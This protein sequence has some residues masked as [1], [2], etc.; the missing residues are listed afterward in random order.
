[1]SILA[2]TALAAAGAASV[3]VEVWSVRSGWSWDAAA[4][5]LLAGLSLLAGAGWATYLTIGCR[6]LLALAG[7][8]WFLATPQVVSGWV[9]HDA[10]LLG[11]VWLAPLA[12]AM[13]ALPA[14]VP[15]GKTGRAAGILAW[16][17]ALPM[18]AGLGWLT[19]ATGGG[20]AFAAAVGS[21]RD[22]VRLPRAAAAAVGAMTGA[23]G[24]LQQVTGQGSALEPFVAVAVAVCGLAVL[25]VR[26]AG[27]ATGS[28]VAG[29]VVELGRATDARSLQSRLARAV[30]DPRLRL[31]YQLAPGL[32]FVT[33]SGLAADATPAGRIVT[34]MG[35]SGPLVAAIEHDNATL[36]DPRLRRAVLVVG[37]LAVRRLTGAA[38]AAQHSLELA[39]SR[40]R[41]VEADTL[42]RRQ[43][44]SEV[45][46]GPA[47]FVAR[48]LEILDEALAAAP[49]NLR[50]DVTA[51]R[52]AA[53]TAREELAGIASGDAD[54]MLAHG[55]L[56]AALTE[57]THSAG[58]EASIRIE[59]ALDPGLSRAA[60]FA[61]AEALTNALKH[62]GPARIWL[63]ASID[64]DVLRVQVEDDGVGG[65]DPAG[66]GLRSLAWRLAEHRG[67]LH[68]RA[69]E[70]GGTVVTADIPLASSDQ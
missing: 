24:I 27:A 47:R 67:T 43:F 60:W 25:T 59:G 38:E 18:L 63:N 58:G 70:H 61:A 36:T 39:D 56:P 64:A 26:P 11:G 44:A 48:C 62:A 41:L 9:G 1:M 28:G 57:L 53:E 40:R 31:L 37:R 4:L 3:A 8:A 46:D 35:Q 16:V 6:R 34:V 20:L 42:A 65:A 55:D 17:R 21:G 12:T 68:V 15:P 52:A 10:A 13:L 22:V 50:A 23:A 45:A 51:A 29:L 49:P 14:A 69:G 5:D 33:A 66:R 54:R 19:A 30:G 7:L 32:P 2:R